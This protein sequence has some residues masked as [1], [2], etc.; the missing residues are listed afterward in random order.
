MTNQPERWRLDKMYQAYL[1]HLKVEKTCKEAIAAKRAEG[2]PLKQ[3]KI[4]AVC[5]IT[6]YRAFHTN[7]MYAKGPGEVITEK[8]LLRFIPSSKTTRMYKAF[9]AKHNYPPN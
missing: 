8:E 9:F 5:S 6:G 3:A 4:A 1:Y 2:M 7:H